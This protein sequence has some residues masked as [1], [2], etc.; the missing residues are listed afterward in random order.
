MNN[1]RDISPVIPVQRSEVTTRHGSTTEEMRRAT[2]N[3]LRYVGLLS[4]LPTRTTSPG[5]GAPPWSHPEDGNLKPP[6]VTGGDPSPSLTVSLPP[7]DNTFF[8]EA[9]TTNF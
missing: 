7:C 8:G 5:V 9:Q 6:R 2:S 3:P 4:Q 1:T